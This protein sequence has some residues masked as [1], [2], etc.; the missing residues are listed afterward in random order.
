MKRTRVS[1]ID[2]GTTKVCTIMG[3]IDEKNNV[4]I[5]GVGIAPSK[6]LTKGIVV[7]LNEA[8]ESIRDSVRIAE[9]TAGFKLE[10]AYVGVTGRHVSSVNNKGAVAISRNDRLVK[11][12]DLKRVLEVARTIEV[13]NDQKVLHVIP[14]AYS[15][16]GQ[17][18]VKNPVGMHGF[19][20]DVETHVIT[21]AVTSVQNLTKCVR[22][23]G[24]EIDDLIL[25]PL[26][27]AEAVLA[28]E[29]RLDG[30]LLADIG[31]STTDIA[32]FKDN[33]ITY[34]SILPVGGYQISRDISIGL[35]LPFEAAEDMKKKYG[36]IT[37][38]GNAEVVE[39]RA[40]NYGQQTL[41]AN[42]L[43]DIIRARMDELIRLIVM[44][45]P[46]K[47]YQHYIPSGLVLTGGGANL[48]GIIESAR[49][50]TRF[51]VRLGTPV[52]LPGVSDALYDPAY[53]TAVG[54][55]LWRSR[56]NGAQTPSA[57]GGLRGV[58]SPILRMIR[59]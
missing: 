24:I 52:N 44:E 30:V 41:S 13:P 1:A 42:D 25:E 57:K 36:N 10:S 58:M 8:R 54:L 47:D 56:N 15:V 35:G 50:I 28:P 7:N 6:G 34:T 26:A 40:I 31:G 46:D 29:E 27:S 12:E 19:R 37:P 22:S 2:V 23:I 18:G 51:P 49:D 4:R 21:A 11:P 3:D 48:G 17:E 43:N 14:R 39:D 59:R 16:D 38:M 9:R 45:L 53:A 5:L 32:V 55:M 33:S 20:L